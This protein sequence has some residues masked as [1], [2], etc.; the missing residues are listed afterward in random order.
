MM[1]WNRVTYKLKNKPKMLFGVDFNSIVVANGIVK[2]DTGSETREF[3]YEEF[4]DYIT[5]WPGV[6]LPVSNDK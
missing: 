3:K 4:T 2:I 5:I 1:K 6:T